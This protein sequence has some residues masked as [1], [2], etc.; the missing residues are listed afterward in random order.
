MG[1]WLAFRSETGLAFLRGRFTRLFLPLIF[2]MCVI[3]V[4]QVWYERLLDGSFSGSLMQFWVLNY[5][6]EG[7]YPTGNFS[8]AHM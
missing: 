2:A 6:T 3:V 5:F 1:T 4:P 7:R 8:W